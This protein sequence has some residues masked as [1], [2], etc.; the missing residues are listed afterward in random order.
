MSFSKIKLNP[1]LI[2]SLSW[3]RNDK[4][5]PTNI[6]TLISHELYTRI[7]Q[8]YVW[9]TLLI[10]GMRFDNN[11]IS[12]YLKRSWR[13]ICSTDISVSEKD[14]QQNTGVTQ[15]II[16]A[17]KINYWKIYVHISYIQNIGAKFSHPIS[18]WQILL[19]YL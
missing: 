7:C 10:R 15:S 19:Y 1:C 12:R 17:T 6:S 18:C 11:I 4:K 13:T 5:K 14:C 2:K 3:T 9:C 8:R 16:M